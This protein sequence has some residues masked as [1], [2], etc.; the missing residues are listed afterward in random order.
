MS[1]LW[2]RVKNHGNQ[3]WKSSGWIPAI[4][5]FRECNQDSFLKQNTKV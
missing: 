4:R 5:L 3:G 1:L 2:H